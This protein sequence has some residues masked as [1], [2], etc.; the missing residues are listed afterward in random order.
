M[1][2][3]CKY[4]AKNRE[5]LDE[6]FHTYKDQDYNVTSTNNEF[7]KYRNNYAVMN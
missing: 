2:C 3:Y 6:Q 1:V 5:R 4:K 7:S